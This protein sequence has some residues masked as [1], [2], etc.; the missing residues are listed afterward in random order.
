MNWHAME[1]AAVLQAL[2]T[3]PRR[4]L[5]DA[6]ARRRLERDGPNELTKEH[7]ASPVALFFGQFKNTLIVILL[8]ATVLS[9]ALGELVDAGIILAIVVFCAG[10]GFL[11]EYR[12]ERALDAVTTDDQTGSDGLLRCMARVGAKHAESRNRCPLLL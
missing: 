12:A 4:G 8:I 10:L 9:A 2:E 1:T 11:Q 5:D 7:R 3:G 6:E